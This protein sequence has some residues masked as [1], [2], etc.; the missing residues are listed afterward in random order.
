MSHPTI[1][2]AEG[3]PAFVVLPYDEYQ[4][5]VAA[6]RPN[7]ISPRVPADDSVP[8]EVMSLK[9]ANDWSLIRAWREYLGITQVEMARRLEIRQPTY[10][11]M[12]APDGRPRLATRRRIADALGVAAEQLEG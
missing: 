5:L 3:R 10:A 12:E 7:A 2:E 6:A 8:H 4:Q 9:V 1:L 11:A